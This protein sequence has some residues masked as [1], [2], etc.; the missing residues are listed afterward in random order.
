MRW[1]KVENKEKINN[2]RISDGNIFIVDF[3]FKFLIRDILLWWN[4]ILYFIFY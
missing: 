4:D 1:K 2:I 3:F